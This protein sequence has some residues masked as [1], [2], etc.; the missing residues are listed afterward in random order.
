MGHHRDAARTASQTRHF[1]RRKQGAGGIGH[2]VSPQ[3][4]P[5]GGRDV[6]DVPFGNQKRPEVG[7]AHAVPLGLVDHLL[8]VDFY[9]AFLEATAHF[10][11]SNLSFCPK[12][13]QTILKG[14]GLG[15]QKQHHYVEPAPI[16]LTGQLHSRNQLDP[17]PLGLFS[18]FGDTFQG[19]VVGEGEGAESDVGGQPHQLGRGVATV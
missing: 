4:V 17:E 19:V 9:A 11:I 1:F 12:L 3:I 13:R 6:R 7:T 16:P 10:P 5:K 2:P 14:S 15:L 8:V 18:G